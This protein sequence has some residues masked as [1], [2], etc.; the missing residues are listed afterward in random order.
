M[1]IH[2]LPKELGMSRFSLDYN[3]SIF[4]VYICRLEYFL[5]EYTA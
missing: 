4:C 1:I 5:Q 2:F 3:D